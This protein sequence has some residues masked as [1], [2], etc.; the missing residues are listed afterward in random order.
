MKKSK[1][2]MLEWVSDVNDY[3][4]LA[5]LSGSKFTYRA[6]VSGILP[7]ERAGVKERFDSWFPTKEEAEAFASWMTARLNAGRK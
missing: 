4:S 1:F 5:P 2:E 3:T 7:G 6:V